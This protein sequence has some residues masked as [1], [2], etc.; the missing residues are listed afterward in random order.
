MKQRRARLVLAVLSA[1]AVLA[2]FGPVASLPVAAA[3]PKAS[4]SRLVFVGKASPRVSGQTS[5]ADGT[6][7]E[8]S[9]AGPVDEQIP[10]SAI[11]AARVPASRVPRPVANAL[12]KPGAE[13]LGTFSGLNHH[14]QRTAGTGAFANTQ[15][16][17][18]PPD[19]ALCVGGSYVVESVNTALAV[20]SKAGGLLAGPTPLNQLFGL[21]PEIDRATGVYGDFT[22]DPKCIYDS[23][24]GG[25]FILTI[26]QMGVNPATG[27][28]DGTSHVMIAVSATN[29]PT[30]SWNVYR[31]DTT[32]DGAGC[33]CL[34]DQPL[35]G[36]DANGF[37][38]TANSYPI[39]GAGFNGAQVYAIPKSQLEG[40]AASIGA[41]KVPVTAPAGFDGPPY[42]LQPA[43]TVPGSADAANTEYFLSSL[44]FTGTL[45]NRIAQW[46]LTGTNTLGTASPSL[47]LTGKVIASEVYG[48]PPKAQQSTAGP[49]PLIDGLKGSTQADLYGAVFDKAAYHVELIDT[50]DDRM[51]EVVYANGKL[52]GALNTVVK[53][54]NGPTQTGIAWFVVDAAASAMANQG[55]LSVNG[56]TLMYP[57]FGVNKDGKGA[58]GVTIVGADRHPSTAY[59]IFDGTGFG[60]VRISH[61][62]PVGDDGFTGYLAVLPNGRPGNQVGVARWGDYGATAVDADGSIWLANETTSTTRSLLANWATQVTHVQP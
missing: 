23:G 62:G 55:Y 7:T 6:S 42:S 54:P 59:A 48:Q 15:F 40:G 16:S 8:V 12:A 2:A 10:N 20:Y 26:L 31:L 1:S 57:A 24:D 41:V 32:N 45:D 61:A 4:I 3:G 18:E 33:P 28:D 38:I 53:T 9:K 50:N 39:F 34:P 58:I 14:D 30:G 37:Y 21:M 46:T 43:K 47:S 17:L 56:E 11:S 25:H 13:Q 36:A 5:T 44:E 29:D 51:Q 52:Y 27:R 19:Q 22:S 35:I 49:F 60:P